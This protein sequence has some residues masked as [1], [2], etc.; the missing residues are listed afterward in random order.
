MLPVYMYEVTN[1]LSSL[2]AG[3]L[4]ERFRDVLL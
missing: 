4:F 3:W 1:F 2:E